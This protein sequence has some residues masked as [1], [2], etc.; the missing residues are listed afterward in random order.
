MP[1]FHDTYLFKVTV[2]VHASDTDLI[3]WLEQW[4][5]KNHVVPK[6][7]SNDLLKI[8]EIFILYYWKNLNTLC[9]GSQLKNHSGLWISQKHLCTISL[10]LLT[11][12]MPFNFYSEDG[13]IRCY[14]S[15]FRMNII[16]HFQLMCILIL[17]T[18]KDFYRFVFLTKAVFCLVFSHSLICRLESDHRGNIILVKK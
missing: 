7:K 17:I 10:S 11:N 1:A 12:H 16:E 13:H 14:F 6:S 2:P 9:H 18:T 4:F 8:N 5:C 3:N 15:D